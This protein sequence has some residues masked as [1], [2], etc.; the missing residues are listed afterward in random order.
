MRI[1]TGTFTAYTRKDITRSPETAVTELKKQKENFE[2]NF[3][4][5]YEI[6]DVVEKFYP[7]EDGIR[8]VLEYTLQGDIAKPVLIEYDNTLN[9]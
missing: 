3:Y 1:R 7:A 6:I 2:R 5:E 8:L 9:N 4:A